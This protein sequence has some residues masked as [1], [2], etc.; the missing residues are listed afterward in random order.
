M[1]LAILLHSGSAERPDEAD[2]LV[3]VEE[4][5]ALAQSLGWQ[6]G[7]LMWN[8][9]AEAVLRAQRP[10]VVIN[11]VESAD[12]SDALAYRAPALL[13]RL[14]VPYTGATTDT[15]RRLAAKDAVKP[16]L[17]AASIP[18]PAWGD[19]NKPL[20]PGDYIIKSITEHGSLGLDAASIV[21]APKVAEAIAHACARHG[22]DWFAEAYIPGREFN[23]ALL[24]TADGVEALPV[25]EMRFKGL[26]FPHI[27]DYA[28]KWD[29]DSDAYRHTS[30][31]FPAPAGPDGP[32]LDILRRSAVECWHAC[33]LK[34]YARVD[35]RVDDRGGAW[36]IDVNPNPC[37]SAD[38]GFMAAAAQAGLPPHM[39]LQR[40]LHDAIAV[41]HLG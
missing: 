35:F 39:V 29:E 25:A 17:E 21:P 27:V 1:S 30:R 6:T 18:T 9:R 5:E 32:L 24:A 2:T 36:V 40:I 11:L 34:G 7:S 20:P 4:L 31:A 14:G 37:L 33:G 8:D 26:S 16:L 10:E 38:A 3:Q 19:G 12:G 13:D 41:H 22:G 28:A 23:L 15:L